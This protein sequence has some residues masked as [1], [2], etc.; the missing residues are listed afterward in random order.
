MTVVDWLL[1]SDPSIRWQVMRDLTGEPAEAVA[2]ERSRVATEGWGARLLALQGED[3]QWGR[4]ALPASS[5]VS[6]KGLPDPGTR[7]LLRDLHRISLD[8]LAEFLDIDS[9]TLSAWENGEPDPKDERVDSYRAALDWM[10]RS[11]GTLKPFWTSTTYTLLLLRDMGLD[12]ASSQARRAVSLVRDNSKWDEGGQ[13]YFD[14]EVEPC[15]NGKAVALGA[16]FG[17]NVGG[18]VERLLGEQ[19]GD[20]GWNCEAERG[21]TR[22]SFNTTIAVLEGL[23]EYERANGAPPDVTGARLRGQEYLLE[24]RMFRRLS[25]GEVVDPAWTRFSFPTGWHYD[26]LRGLD[27]LRSAGV[28]P[29]ERCAEAIDLVEGRR[30]PD[31][32]WPLENTHPGRVHFDMDEGDGKPSHWNTLRAMRVLAWYGRPAL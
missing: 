9:D 15:I 2:A 1:D 28:E 18:I 4:D 16:Y 11:L 27:Y 5:D 26:V 8:E 19:L 24:R 20:G 13:D 12:P 6:E 22:S 14:G 17:E 10:R 30:D 29:D 25:T 23:L 3:G 32:R 31:G 21:S 7:R